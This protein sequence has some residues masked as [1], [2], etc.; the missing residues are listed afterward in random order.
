MRQWTGDHALRNMALISEW[1]NDEQF[2]FC[3]RRWVGRSIYLE[4]DVKKK[5]KEQKS[6]DSMK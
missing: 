6:V 4:D 3:N 5:K 1:W 2:F